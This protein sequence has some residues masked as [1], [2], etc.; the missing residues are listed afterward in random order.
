MILRIETREDCCEY[1]NEP[2]G[3]IKGEK[4]LD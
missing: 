4:F 2:A 1:G 3:S